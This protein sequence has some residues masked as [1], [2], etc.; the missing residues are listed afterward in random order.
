MFTLRANDQSRLGIDE[1][2]NDAAV[3]AQKAHL[4]DEL[5]APAAKLD[6]DGFRLRPAGLAPH[7]TK[8][9]KEPMRENHFARLGHQETDA[10][11]LWFRPSRGA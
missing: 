7:D 6:P 2:V 5:L 9:L 8:R 1:N 4:I 10:V 11:R 3:A